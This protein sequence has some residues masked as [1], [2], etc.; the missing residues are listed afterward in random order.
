MERILWNRRSPYSPLRL[1]PLAAASMTSQAWLKPNSGIQ[2]KRCTASSVTSDLATTMHDFF[3]FLR[4]SPL[5]LKIIA[6]TVIYITSMLYSL[7]RYNKGEDVMGNRGL[8]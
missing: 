2:F 3:K 6:I 5:S 1:Y 8:V 7:R 4:A